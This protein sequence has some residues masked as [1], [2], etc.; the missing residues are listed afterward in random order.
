LWLVRERRKE[1]TRATF[2]LAASP[3]SGL[4]RLFVLKFS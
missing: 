1:E 2:R 3:G 4:G